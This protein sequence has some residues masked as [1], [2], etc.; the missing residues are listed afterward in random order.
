[1]PPNLTQQYYPHLYAPVQM[2]G[3]A[4]PFSMLAASSTAFHQVAMVPDYGPPAYPLA[5]LPHQSSTPNALQAASAH[6]G[7]SPDA[8]HLTP[9][10]A[11][12]ANAV[13]QPY[14]NVSTVASA[15]YLGA[16]QGADPACSPSSGS[17]AQPT[18]DGS[19]TQRKRK[20][21]TPRTLD[22]S[23]KKRDNVRWHTTRSL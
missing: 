11:Q 10:A 19:V 15:G 7:V 5:Q 9:H 21:M 23:R 1:M 6:H 12:C 2:L 20:W 16:N 4:A 17:C 18:Q 8:A 22:N 13:Q 14:P 3:V